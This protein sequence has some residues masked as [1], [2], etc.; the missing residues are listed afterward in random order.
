V[1]GK[2]RRKRAAFP[3]ADAA[4]NKS[5]RCRVRGDGSQVLKQRRAAASSNKFLSLHCP[6]AAH[7]MV[8]SRT[9]WK[10]PFPL[11]RTML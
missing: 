9:F 2:L 1:P 4:T 6:A 5:Y 11:F 7:E 3:A 8:Y 10:N